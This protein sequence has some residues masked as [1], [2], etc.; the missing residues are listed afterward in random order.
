MFVH[1][2]DVIHS[3]VKVFE[4]D[5][6]GLEPASYEGRRQAKDGAK[7]LKKSVKAIVRELPLAP[8]VESA[9]KHAVGEMPT[10]DLR[11]NDLRHNLTDVVK[12]A[13]E[14]AVSGIVRKG[15]SAQA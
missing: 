2:R 9:L 4:N 8:I 6:A 10:F 5:W 13:V 12:E 3:L 15:V 7:A 14:A 1:D 11:G